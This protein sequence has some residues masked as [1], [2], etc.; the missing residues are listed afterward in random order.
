MTQNGKLLKDIMDNIFEKGG[1]M[2]RRKD[3]SYSQ[4][5][6]WDNI[7]ANKGS[8]KKPT[9]EMLEQERKIRAQEK[10]MG[11]AFYPMMAQGGEPNGE[12]ALGQM[13][14]VEDKMRKLLQFVKPGDNLDPWIASKLA[15]MDHSADAI[16]DYLMYGPNAPEEQMMGKGGY[17]VTRSNDRKGKTHKVTGPD[18]TVKYFGDAKLGQHPKDPE[19]KKAFYARHKKNLD[20]NPYFRAFA[21]A[22]WAD[23]GSTDITQ[24][25]INNNPMYSFYDMMAMGG[26]N[27]PGFQALPDHVQAKIISNMA[28]GGSTFSGNAW[29][30]NGGYMPRAMYGWGMAD[31]GSPEGP[32][33]HPEWEQDP[34]AEYSGQPTDDEIIAG[35]DAQNVAATPM[36]PISIKVPAAAAPAAPARKSANPNVSIVDFLNSQGAKSDFATRKAVAEKVYGFDNYTGTAEQNKRLLEIMSG[37]KAPAAGKGYNPND[38]NML[39]KGWD[40]SFDKRPQPWIYGPKKADATEEKPSTAEQA[41]KSQETLKKKALFGKT[42]DEF[43]AEDPYFFAEEGDNAFVKAIDSPFTWLRNQGA[44]VVL[45]QDPMALLQLLGAGLLSR[46]LVGKTRVEPYG[47]ATKGLPGGPN[48]ALPG[49]GPRQLPAPR[50]VSTP[51]PG[52][53]SGGY[54]KFGEDFAP[55]LGPQGFT[56][57]SGMRSPG[58]P[59]YSAGG[60]V[61]GQEIE[62]TDP[63]Q[64]RMLQEGGYTYEII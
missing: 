24:N 11:G 64:L 54:M 27:N 43:I 8:G 23:G 52:A 62:I 26:I 29:Y 35:Q 28:K 50:P 36:A 22:T 17:V 1:Q 38:G 61:E 41:K 21:R 58:Y 51:R 44:R 60:Y 20:R 13:A 2:I 34:Y 46:G 49:P 18:G 19:R 15:V 14:A 30:G 42:A 53:P 37:K 16:S 4:R 59:M 56:T 40:Q 7:R 47:S 9:R 39:R 63:E 12:M 10:A 48:K 45:D 3:G 6:L 32:R 55:R 5:G 31:G 33:W 57:G 25:D